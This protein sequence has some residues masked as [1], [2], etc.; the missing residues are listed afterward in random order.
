MKFVSSLN[1]V[2]FE[3]EMKHILKILFIFF[4]ISS[5]KKEKT[6]NLPT[7][8]TEIKVEY[9]KGFRIFHFDD[10]KKI[11]VSSPWPE[12]KETFTYILIEKGVKKP[13]NIE[14]DAL[15]EIPVNKLVVTSTT[16]IPALEALGVENALVGFPSTQYISS[17]KT[18]KNIDLGKIKELGINESI[19]TE[20][21]IDLQPDF[22]VGFS[23]DS[24]NKTYE[25]IKNSGIPIVYNGDWVEKTPLGKS[26]WI[27]FFAPFFN[28]EKLADSI[29]SSIEKEYINAQ[30]IAQ[31]AINRPTVLSG[32][33]F[34]DVWY[35][36]TG[37]SWVAQFLKDANT[38]Y[39]WADTKGSGSISL[40]FE[41]VLEKAQNADFWM[42]TSQFTSYKQLDEN[43]THYS[44]F[45]AYK[46][47]KAYTFSLT[48]GE[49]GGLLYYELAPSRPD[50]V[51]KDLITIFHPGILP[52]H[53]PFFFKPLE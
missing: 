3:T 35:M 18:R 5:C 34:K 8:P 41:S 46:N 47:K 9:A 23:I 36:P 42:G 22:V 11:E 17:K 24:Y 39:L 7:P 27:K 48:K 6:T 44:Q 21:L 33:M 12:S 29:F 32:A 16:H 4:F 38:N 50:I 25:T 45:E 10:Y 52:N 31:K 2:T 13:A 43:N 40:S 51:L 37:E 30:K 49:S 14:Y 53:Q 26:E 1:N 20:I 15:I 28:K 19:N